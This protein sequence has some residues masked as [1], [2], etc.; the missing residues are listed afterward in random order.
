MRS[1]THPD[2]SRSKGARG[3]KVDIDARAAAQL[4]GDREGGAVKF[5]EPL[6]QRETEPDAFEAPREIAL[7]LHER[8]DDAVEIFG[9]DADTA[10]LDRE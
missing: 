6:A 3:G 2:S 4:A 9:G 5:R 7:D 1:G 8:F 10:I